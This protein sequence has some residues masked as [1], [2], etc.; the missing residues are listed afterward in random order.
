M[1]QFIAQSGNREAWQVAALAALASV[2]FITLVACFVV[3]RLRKHNANAN[4]AISTMRQGICMF[5]GSE[6]LVLLNAPYIDIYG[7]SP[8]IV[9]VGATLREVLAHRHALGM[10]KEDPEVYRRRLLAAVAE[11]RTIC[12]I[13]DSGK[14]RTISVVNRP[15]SGGGWLG[16]HDDITEQRQLET[17]R[18]LM[19]AQE[20]RRKTIDAA[21]TSF[22]GKVETLLKTVGDSAQ[23]MKTTATSLSGSSEQTLRRAEGAV[24]ASSDASGGVKTAAEAADELAISISEIGRQLDQTNHLVRSAVEEAQLTKSGIGTL[25]ESAQKIGDVVNLIRDIASQTNL[26]AL[27]AT[28]EAA[29]AGQAGRGFA[30]VASEVKTLA[31]QTAKATEEITAQITAVQNSTTG[32]VDAIRRIVDSMQEVSDH[33]SAVAASVEEQNAATNQISQNV[34]NADEGAQH[35]VRVLDEVAGAA[36]ETSASAA[37]MLETSRSVETT[38]SDLRQEVENFLGKVAV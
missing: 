34:A 30:V 32:A 15:V 29:R 24:Q 11:G 13:V 5:D 33:T 7:H 28:I 37:M 9:K 8:D 20:Q 3:A 2:F 25:A 12:G 6:R 18:E 27:N 4:A 1:L 36:K 21:I 23:A 35:S 17:E 16:T 14:G 26:L 22:R 31:V 38:V 19:V 10:L